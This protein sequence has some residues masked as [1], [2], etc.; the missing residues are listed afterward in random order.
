VGA[1]Q[2]HANN[3][4]ACGESRAVRCAR[5]LFGEF[6][7]VHTF[8]TQGALSAARNSDKVVGMMVQNG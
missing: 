5:E 3:P 7:H 6:A 2:A 8:F 1:A 4:A